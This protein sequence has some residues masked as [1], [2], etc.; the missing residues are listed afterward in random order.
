M[1]FKKIYFPGNQYVQ[2]KTL[3]DIFV[4]HHS[5][6]W[7][8]ARSMYNQWASDTRRVCTA[9]GITDNGTVYQGF[10]PVHW[11]FALGVA[12][13][14]N[15]VNKIYKTELHDVQLNSR[16]IQVE[17]CNWG[18]LFEKNN[19]LYAWPAHK[20]NLS[21]KYEVP[22]SRAICYQDGFRGFEWYERY[23]DDEIEAL[24]KLLLFHHEKDG[25][26]LEYNPDM[27]DISDKALG[28][29]PGLWTH[30]S[31]RSDKSDC[32]PQPELIEMLK[33]LKKS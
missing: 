5:A 12:A 28:G 10:D 17:L 13:K 32:H 29:K 21:S 1:E 19:K 15:M 33:S 9:Y 14:G 26:M 7:D 20:G 30:V 2:K 24:R 22:K 4:I 11:G 31:Y 6:G 27:W 8:D 23:T 3:K 16:A 18:W 25:I